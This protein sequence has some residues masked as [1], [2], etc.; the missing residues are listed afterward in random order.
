MVSV[1]SSPDELLTLR[2][3]AARLGVHENTVR[4]WV[5][6]GTLKSLRAV[7]TRGHR[8]DPREVERV[9]LARLDVPRNVRDSRRVVGSERADATRLEQW[10]ATRRAQ[11]DFPRLVRRLLAATPGI[12]QLSARAGEGIH[13][14]GWDV[15]AHVGRKTSRLPA[16]PIV[17]E[18][19]VGSSPATKANSEYTKRTNDTP[20]A[21]RDK[22]T[23]AFATPRRWAGKFDWADKCHSEGNWK[24][25]LA[26]DADDIDAW[27]EEEQGVS[28]WIAE[29]IGLE[30][31]GLVTTE[32][33]WA[34]FSRRTEPPLPLRLLLAG[35]EPERAELTQRLAGDQTSVAVRAPWRDEALAFICVALDAAIDDDAPTYPGLIVR[36][37]RV[38]RR[39]V[40]E[41]GAM[42]LIPIFEDP[43]IR[44]AHEAGKRVVIPLGANDV[45]TGS[46]IVLERPDR[47]AAREAFTERDDPEVAVGFQEADAHAALSRRSV[48][49]LVRRLS[50]GRGYP[51]PTWAEDDAAGIF[52]P[53]LFAGAWRTTDTDIEILAELLGQPWSDVERKV[54]AAARSADPPVIRSGGSWRVVS[55]EMVFDAIREL[56][57]SADLERLVRVVPGVLLERDSNEGKDLSELLVAARE[58]NI[59]RTASEQLRHGLAQGLA[60]LGAH[61]DEPLADRSTNAWVNDATKPIFDAACADASGDT[62]ARLSDVLPF[63]A[64]AAPREFL[65]RVLSQ[66]SKDTPLLA[67]IFRDDDTR[68]FGGGFPHSGL[69]WA[70]ETLSWSDDFLLDA[71]RAL[72]QL[73]V[74]DPGGKMAN[75][76]LTSLKAILLPWI[77]HTGATPERKREA[78]DQ[79]VR[80]FPS[81]AWPLLNALLPQ[82]QDAV[83]PP[84]APCFGLWKPRVQ[85]VPPSEWWAEVEHIVEIVIAEAGTDPARL[86]ELAERLSPLPPAFRERVLIALED[87]V[88]R[89]AL[90]P[91]RRLQ[92]WERLTQEVQRHRAFAAAAW[93]LSE[94]E[95]DRL[96]RLADAIEPKGSVE[97]YARLFDW[98]PELG[99]VSLADYDAYGEKLQ[100]L[101]RE[102]V[103]DTLVTAGT[104]GLLRLAERAPAAEELGRLVGEVTGDQYRD[105]LLSWLGTTGAQRAVAYAWAVQRSNDGGLGWTVQALTDVAG[106]EPQVLLALAAQPEPALWEHLRTISPD[107]ENRYWERVSPMGIVGEAVV[108]AASEFARRGREW[109]AI[110]LLAANFHRKE[111]RADVSPDFVLEVLDAAVTS[112][113]LPSRRGGAMLGYE[114][115]MLLDFLAARSIDDDVLAGVEF[116]YFE[117]TQQHRQPAALYRVLAR[118]PALFV[119]LMESVFSPKDAPRAKAGQAE[120]ANI[121]LAYRVLND[122]RTVPGVRV[123]GAI[124]EQHLRR[125]V[126][127]ARL[128]LSGS[129]RGDVA[130][131]QIGHVLAGSPEGSDGAW[132]HEAVRDLIERVGSELIEAGIHRG[133]GLGFTSRDIFEGGTIERREA[134][135]YR[136]WARTIEGKWPRTA[137]LLGEI[138]E[139]FERDAQQWDAQAQERA[140]TG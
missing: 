55:H 126:D 94:A 37:P 62:W 68:P 50:Q 84:H 134:A 80:D 67:A 29:Q 69:L 43:E 99:D 16:G 125:W 23:F 41:P 21:V 139:R 108:R 4:N 12:T 24:G 36:S 85:Q 65:R 96:S 118:D 91:P 48:Q 129:G 78:L 42:T 72:A 124:D 112:P 115:S 9:R 109:S 53:L 26:L 128:A 45:A 103:T 73:A 107:L 83:M 18:L 51:L 104:A 116:R 121:T 7:G 70:L 111:G 15:T 31:D 54:R 92:L 86:A 33:W 17:F 56:I 3:V 88:P 97:R 38:W 98:H 90:E 75:R 89:L 49:A 136:E 46:P 132:P 140:D 133:R 59:D 113:E 39:L 27:L 81:A 77:R 138:A 87:L 106:D 19:G 93:A 30:P 32:Q 117:I 11:E 52:A 44:A 82:L 135:R 123:D 34:E 61:P 60:L 120:S 95:V 66:S 79:I 6:L 127:K 28:Y 74:I 122:W 40:M 114:V 2:E 5:K 102:A 20:R 131:E 101:R 130:D 8:F 100:W 22:T 63:I 64:E 14:G 119:R 76:P 71:T 57:T 35:R 58:G 110:T 10:A 137:R 105:E 47:V 1:D 25:V 13:L